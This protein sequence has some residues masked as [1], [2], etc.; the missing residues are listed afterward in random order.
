[1]KNEI[2]IIIS[3]Y[4]KEY[5]IKKCI[6]SVLEQ[7]KT[8]KNIIVVNN[9]STDNSTDVVNEII[10]NNPTINIKLINESRQGAQYS[11]HAGAMYSS[12]KFVAFL[13][14]DDYMLPNHIEVVNDL[15]NKYTDFDVFCS[16]YIY[17]FNN[18]IS[19]SRNIENIIISKNKEI[20]FKN[21]FYN[22]GMLC[23][24]NITCKKSLINNKWIEYNDRIGEDLNIWYNIISNTKFVC[25][26]NNTIIINKTPISSNSS[27]DQKKMASEITLKNKI[28]LKESSF[29][30]EKIVFARRMIYVG[31]IIGVKHLFSKFHLLL[32]VFFLELFRILILKFKN[33]TDTF[34]RKLKIKFTKIL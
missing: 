11:R 5:E 29:F 7:T 4:N 20:F 21:Y 12:S 33:G 32:T 23:S 19:N 13:D 15:I 27:I 26:N 8:P 2:D 17:E 6:K 28:K 22:R 18:Q 31:K 14:G 10:K 1:M 3:L 25:A 9:N 16:S 34:K 30:Y 24:S